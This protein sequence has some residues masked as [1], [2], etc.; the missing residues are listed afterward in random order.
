MTNPLLISKKLKPIFTVS[1]L[2]E[3]L[4]LTLSPIRATVEGEITEIKV[5]QSI[6]LFITLADLSEKATIQVFG[7]TSEINNWGVLKEGMKVKVDGKPQI[8]KKSGHFSLRAFSIMPSGEGAL[9]AAF[10]ILKN[11]LQKEGLF[12]PER[13]RSIPSFPQSIGLITALGS[14]AFKDFI[15]VL[16]H[17]LGGLT[18][19]FYPVQVEGKLA[20]TSIL[21]A[22]KF[23]EEK[24]KLI[25]VLALVRGGG[26]LEQLSA[27]NSEEVARAIFSVQ[28]PA[29]VGVGH[30]GDITLADLVADLRAST[31]SNAAELLV[32]D[33]NE[34]KFQVNF[35]TDEIERILRHVLEIKR[36]QAFNLLISIEHELASQKNQTQDL[37]QKTLY[38]LERL[39]VNFKEKR[40]LFK[41]LMQNLLVSQKR[42]IINIKE[43][44]DFLK[45]ELENLSPLNI[46]KRG[47]SICLTNTD[48]LITNP[49]EV[50]VGSF[51][52]N[53]FAQGK[54]TSIVKKRQLT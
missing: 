20:I 16:S 45:K 29:V 42:W 48:K 19:Y 34:L 53:L 25:E 28:V 12:A 54:I 26:S 47:Y 17:R 1:E 11:K 13:K 43:K 18:I 7:L 2:I 3:Y 10:E 33:R 31:P 41:G 32:R 30:E 5:S 8:F 23:F 39:G 36:N 27:F 50:G 40:A 46:L 14:Q 9:K 38:N 4:N 22:L 44:V 49:M 37:I 51:I 15:K 6:Y 52:T 24:P 35:L 21:S